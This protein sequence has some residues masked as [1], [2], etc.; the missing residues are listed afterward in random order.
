MI[1]DTTH[2]TVHCF[3]RL[4]SD[5][6]MISERFRIN[7]GI[8]E[9]RILFEIQNNPYIT[10]EQIAE[11]INKTPRTAENHIA[12]LKKKG[13][14]KRVSPKLGGHWKIIT[15]NELWNNDIGNNI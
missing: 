6:G 8:M 10:A 7:F 2:K 5:F 9:L 13:I 12:K 11:K 15:K 1:L 14:L 4:R 3:G